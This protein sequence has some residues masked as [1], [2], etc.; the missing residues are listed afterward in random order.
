[1]TF[2]SGDIGNFDW[3]SVSILSLLVEPGSN[4]GAGA[5]LVDNLRL[6]DTRG[7]YPDLD[8]ARDAAGH[9]AA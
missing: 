7:S 1:M 3:H 5:F 8:A 4:P 9:I 2:S 6:V